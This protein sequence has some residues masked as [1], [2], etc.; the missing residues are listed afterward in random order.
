MIKE[1]I[2]SVAEKFAR[3]NA[4]KINEVLALQG[5]IAANALRSLHE[6][7]YLSDAEFKVFSQRG[8][9]GILEWL[10]QR[11]PVSDTRFIEF[12]VESYEEA[13]TRFLMMNRNWKG[14]VI[15]S[16]PDLCGNVQKNDLSAHYS[17]KALRSFITRENIN[18][19]F[20]DSGFRCEIGVLSIDIDGN[21]YWVWEAI[22]VVRPLIVVCEYNAVLGDLHAVSI[23]YDPKFVRT[24]SNGGNLYY[25]ASIG[26][27]CRLGEAKGYSFL[28]TT[29][30]G[31]DA[32]F[33]RKDCYSIVSGLVHCKEPHPSRVC[34]SRDLSGRLTYVGGLE[35]LRLIEHLPVVQ[36]D[37]GETVSIKSLGNLYSDRW[38]AAM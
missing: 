33:V 27:M 35:R 13:N 21:D 15:D 29:L 22:H 34:E 37:T 8:E 17:L 3:P 1:A 23:P 30:H 24:P 16:H 2:Y 5:R 25:G 6:L 36:I 4:K 26:A 7:Q 18:D 31:N 20:A 19:L 11:L 38:L 10:I 28:G 32:F 14:L 12:G 9:D